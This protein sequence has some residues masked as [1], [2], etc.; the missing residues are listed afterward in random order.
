[1][2][3]RFDFT[4]DN[5]GPCKVPSPIQLSKKH[6]DF[7]A[8]YVKD[9]EFVRYNVDVYD[10]VLEKEAEAYNGPS[11]IIGYAPCEL[12]GI[13]KGGMNH[14]Q[15]EMKFAVIYMKYN[16]YHNEYIAATSIL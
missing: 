4:V 1:M 14:C 9:N 2:K 7:K 8:N 6:G 12:H 5:L 10:D 3:G 13:A 11:L 16:K 15:D